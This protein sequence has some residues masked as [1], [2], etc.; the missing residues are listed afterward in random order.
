[1]MFT[2][3]DAFNFNV[4]SV[5]DGSSK[6]KTDKCNKKKAENEEKV[7][8]INRQ[9]GQIVTQEFHAHFQFLCRSSHQTNQR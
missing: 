3:C 9:M 1:M 8:K 2:F 6:N 4:I 5:D 7:R